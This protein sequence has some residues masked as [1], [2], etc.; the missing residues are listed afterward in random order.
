[1]SENR[2]PSPGPGTYD[3]SGKLVYQRPPTFK[4]EVVFLPS[5]KFLKDASF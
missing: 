3:Q 5:L 4:F 1:M 2:S